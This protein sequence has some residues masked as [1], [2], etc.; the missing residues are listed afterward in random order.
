MK[1]ELLNKIIKSKNYGEFQII[2]I[3][4]QGK[5][6]IR[7][8]D[9]GYENIVYKNNAKQGAVKD[10]SILTLKYKIGDLLDMDDGD[11]A[12]II[13]FKK[14]FRGSRERLLLDIEF[15][16]TGYKTTIF[17]ENRN[18]KDNLKPS[19][20]NIGC[21]GYINNLTTPL[22]EMQEYT[23][24]ADMISRCYS[25]KKQLKNP[26]YEK[27]EICDR[28][29]RFDYFL[30]DISKIEGYHLWKEYKETHPNNKNIYEID[31]D[32]KKLNNKIYSLETC[33]FLVK[34]INAGFT[35]LAKEETKERL[36]ERIKEGV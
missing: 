19:I 15:V 33:R 13:G 29:K 20:C 7:F 10:N 32:T 25:R 31:K 8:L 14:E 5:C 9:T 27:A 3:L 17:P 26:C 18:T 16:S 30:E 35:S 6:K 24:W 36:L 2:E 1:E 12:K 11:K 34:D 4:P 28:W 21:L 22:N 23:L